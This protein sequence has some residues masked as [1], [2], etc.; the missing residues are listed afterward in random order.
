MELKW[1]TWILIIFSSVS[2]RSSLPNQCSIWRVYSLLIQ[3]WSSKR[4]TQILHLLASRG[5]SQSN[6]RLWTMSKISLPN[7]W[8]SC[9]W[10]HLTNALVSVWVSRNAAWTTNRFTF[11]LDSSCPLRRWR[12][13]IHITTNPNLVVFAPSFLCTEQIFSAL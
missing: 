5:S 7:L 3:F 2:G 9:I 11:L 8:A 13:V 1:W 6:K 10:I 4:T 12:Y